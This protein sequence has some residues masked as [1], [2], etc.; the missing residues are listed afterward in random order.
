[1]IS[2]V[3]LAAFFVGLLS[4]LTFVFVSDR[5]AI[6]REQAWWEELQAD[7]LDH[8]GALFDW[9]QEGGL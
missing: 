5:R 9:E 8:Y 1:M 7:A 4:M 6:A 3:V 2:A